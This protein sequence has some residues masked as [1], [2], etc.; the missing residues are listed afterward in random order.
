MYIV[1]CY[2]RITYL[3]Y[4]NY[5]FFKCNTRKYLYFFR[6]G[7]FLIMFHNNFHI[8]FNRSPAAVINIIVVNACV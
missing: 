7:V 2:V 4:V 3:T 6:D 1:T 5:V 8:I